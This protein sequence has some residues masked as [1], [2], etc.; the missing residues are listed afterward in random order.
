MSIILT[1]TVVVLGLISFISE[2]LPADIT[3]LSI[4]IA[5]ML[6]GLVTP[7]EGISGFSNPATVTVMAMFILSSGITKTGVIQVVR[8]RIIRWAGNNPSQ[9]VFVMGSIVGPISGFINNTAI[10]AIFLPIIEEWSKRQKISPS[11]LLIP[12]SY[13]TILGGL[14]TLIGTSTNILASGVSAQLGYGEFS[15]FQFT[16][17]GVL[18]FII[19]LTYLALVAPKLLPDHQTYLVGED[20]NLKDYVSEVVI[21]PRSSLIGKTLQRTKIQR[22]FDL[23]VLEIIRD[24]QRFS[25]PLG[26][27]VLNAGDILVIRSSRE[28]LLKIR[29]SRGLE[30]LADVKFQEQ[31]IEK[32]IASG[33]EKIAEVLI[34]S[35][36]RLIGT[37]LKELRF[38][39]RY[40]ATVLAI[41]RGA[42][43]VQGRLGKIR[44]KF[45]DLLLVQGP[46]QSF[47]GL[48]TTR[49][50]LV[51]EEKP[52]DISRRQKAKT[53][54]GITTGVI[55]LAA[56]NILPILV[57]SLTGVVLMIMTGCLKPGEVYGSV[58][59]DVIF[60]LA[61]LI[62]LGIAMN[63]S[64]ATQWLAQKLIHLGGNFS[65]YWIL[66]FF[67]IITSLLTEILSNN[68]SVILMLPIAVEVA[69]TLDLNPYAFMYAVVFAASNSFMTP[70]GYQTNAMVYSPGGYKFFDFTKVGAPLSILMM[71]TVPLLIN[72]IYGL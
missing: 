15:V 16:K 61:S 57:S 37:T 60:L 41:R 42:E 39:Q 54:L 65:G 2:W 9:Q 62:P 33:E 20:Y 45:G 47:L 68:A 49:E 53:A 43:F 55:V 22:K 18:V 29:E 31:P 14:L 17:L 44:L 19:G 38:R 70:I 67:F 10:V 12:L 63:K 28:E 21:S 58:R 35:N 51:L 26:D 24:K 1:L 25:Q 36:S 5:L 6:L 7:E 69:K 50:L 64:G 13:S 46:R 23:D 8:N 72:F 27:K 56:F 34:L 48:Q 30:I 11:K 59:W 66:F 3:A 52:V 4:A 32:V 40:N 71:F